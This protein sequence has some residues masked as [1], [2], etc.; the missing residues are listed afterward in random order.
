LILEGLTKLIPDWGELFAMSA[1][2]S[3]ELNKDIL[4]WVVDDFIVFST[5]DNNN[6][7]LFFWDS[8]GFKMSFDRSIFNSINESTDL[9]NG[10]SVNI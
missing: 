7:T 1:P 6:V 4:G 10:N 5:D 3:V 9:I 2:W 8:S